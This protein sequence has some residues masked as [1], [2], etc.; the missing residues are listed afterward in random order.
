[1]ESLSLSTVFDG[2][3]GYQRSLVDAVQPLTPEQ[4]AFR[5]A[6]SFRCTGEIVRHIA[7][8]R[9]TWFVRMG[10]PGSTDLARLITAWETDNEGNRYVR[11]EA[12]E[13]TTS[14]TELVSWLEGTWQM[15]NRTLVAWKVGDL[16]DTYTHLWNGKL[17]AISHQWTLFRILAHD[18]HHGGEL[19]LMLGL[20][21]IEAFELGALGGHIV[22][23]P[24]ASPSD[25][26]PHPAR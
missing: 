4:L 23:P 16:A 14:A 3:N 7:L 8:G 19:S 6:P 12:Y 15:I 17:W 11:E 22:L 18:I 1:M 21:G 5:P 9:V 2:W 20:Q 26:L 10:A 13:I 24:A 25:G